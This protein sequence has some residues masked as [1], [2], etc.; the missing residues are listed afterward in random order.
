MRLLVTGPGNLGARLLPKLAR[1]G[2]RGRVL[3]RRA[4]VDVPAGWETVRADLGDSPATGEHWEVVEL[5]ARALRGI[6]E[7]VR[8][9]SLR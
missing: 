9:F 3:H 2:V 7:P 4:A 5:S 6:G 8:L 1:L